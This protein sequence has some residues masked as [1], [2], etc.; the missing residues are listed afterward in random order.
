MNVA[1]LIVTIT[2]IVVAAVLLLAAARLRARKNT[3]NL[4]DQLQLIDVDAFRNLLSETEEVYL[5]EHLQPS[6]FRTIHRE[7]MLAA[8]EYVRGAARNAALLIQ[9]G[10]AGRHSPDVAVAAAAER[11]QE[12]A[13][14][15]R[16]YALQVLPRIYMAILFPGISLASLNVVDRYDTLR[17]QMVTLRCLQS[18]VRS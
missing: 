9:L 17:R 18:P 6:E 2:L 12:N 11:L 1:L 15:L 5:R 4:A 16:I 10:E 13:F 8:S 7:R 3:L 14:R